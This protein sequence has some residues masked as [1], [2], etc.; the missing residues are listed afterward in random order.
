MGRADG[1]RGGRDSR[2]L[3]SGLRR[4]AAA[5][6]IHSTDTLP[7]LLPRLRAV[8]RKRGS[9]P[10][11]GGVRPR[12]RAFNLSFHPSAERRQHDGDL[13]NDENDP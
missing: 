2:R 12:A 7:R 11:G 4:A 8:A 3:I 1:T 9:I 10:F 6:R 13:E 5:F